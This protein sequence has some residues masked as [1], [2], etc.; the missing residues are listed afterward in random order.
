MVCTTMCSPSV[1]RSSRP[2]LATRSLRSETS[3]FSTCLREKASSWR[4]SSEAFWPASEMRCARLVM[5]GGTLSSSRMASALASTMVRM[6]LKSCATPPVSWPTASIF[7]ACMSCSLVRRWLLASCA[8][9][10]SN[11]TATMVSSR[12]REAI[13]AVTPAKT[14]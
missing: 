9:R 2:V 7:C 13:R 4:V 3:G 6:L 14:E 11:I 5:C 10:R 12:T 1:R 8:T